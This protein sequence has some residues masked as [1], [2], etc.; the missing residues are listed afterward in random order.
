MAKPSLLN[1][2]L[3]RQSL[4][5]QFRSISLLTLV[6]TI[7]ASL[8]TWIISVGY[9]FAADLGF[10]H[11][12]NTYEQQIPAILAYVDEQRD[13]LLRPEARAALEQLIPAEGI[14]YQV[15]TAAGDKLYGTLEG[16]FFASGK[17][18]VHKLNSVDSIADG[19]FLRVYPV[20]DEGGTLRG[21]VLLDYRLSLADANQDRP[22][23]ARFFILM[24]LAV[25]FVW[26]SFFTFYYGRRLRER[27]KPEVG[28][29]IDAAHRIERQDLDFTLR[30]VSGAKELEELGLAFERMRAA[31]REALSREWRSNQERHDMA[32]AIA[33]DLRTPLTI[34][35]GHADGL[36]ESLE[37]GGSIPP[38]RL[39][40]YVRTIRHNTERA[41]RLIQEM[42]QVTELQRE[43]F[44]LTPGAV[45]VEPFFSRKAEE[46]RMLAA[47]KK[48]RLLYEYRDL[49]EE[50]RPF[51]LDA[52]RIEQV[53]DNLAANSIRFTPEGGELRLAIRVKPGWIEA[54]LRDS[55]PG[56]TPEDLHHLFRLFYRGDPARS[57]SGSHEKG[58]SGLGLYLVR[59]LL[60]KHGGDIEAANHPDGG[61]WLRFTLRELAE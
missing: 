34:V 41:A 29:L 15:V 21:A 52:S 17:A 4:H 16:S 54:E 58:H 51:W 50:A 27:I 49:R 47:A 14:R 22:V 10:P 11:P 53:L 26:L 19:S 46:Y 39:D 56:F 37:S 60:H 18:L 36:M 35:L 5:Q 61:A 25:P 40:R 8:F 7:A 30:T 20:L 48:Q 31:L 28:Y 1:R 57:G 9:V 6:S 43:G 13:A 44:T 2:W 42:N 45:L 24:N 32:A 23:L 59:T 33:H 55:G 12:A 38:E 3:N